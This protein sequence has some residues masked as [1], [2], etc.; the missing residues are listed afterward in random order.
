VRTYPALTSFRGSAVNITLSVDEQTLN[1][2]R[3]VA[4][5][6]NKSL[7]QMVREYLEQLA[8]QDQVERDIATFRRL[9]PSGTRSWKFNR[10]DLYD[11]KVL[12]R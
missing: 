10:E 6:M 9:S 7:N 4:R 2:A 12:S 11:R 8:G 5:A 3:R 1:K